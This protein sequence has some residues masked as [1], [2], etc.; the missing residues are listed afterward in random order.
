MKMKGAHAGRTVLVGEQT[1]N[2]I[3]LVGAPRERMYTKE[4]KTA[5]DASLA[6]NRAS[7]PQCTALYKGWKQCEGRALN[8]GTLCLG[9]APAHAK[10][11][12][13]RG[14][15]AFAPGRSRWDGRP[16]AFK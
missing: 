4:G 5:L 11:A 3:H 2:A 6:K 15:E 10:T 9:H 7:R 1:D 8:G 12:K 13:Y 16:S 14:S